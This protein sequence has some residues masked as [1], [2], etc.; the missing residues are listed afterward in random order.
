MAFRF[1]SRKYL[2]QFVKLI[3]EYVHIRVADPRPF[4]A[5]PALDKVFDAAPALTALAPAPAPTILYI[6][7]QND[8]V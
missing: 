3:Y 4:N 1:H 8:S 7:S 5:A 2:N 6:L